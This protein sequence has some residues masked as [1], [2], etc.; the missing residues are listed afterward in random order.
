MLPGK[1]DDPVDRPAVFHKR[2]F[3]SIVDTAT[4]GNGLDAHSVR[5]NRGREWSLAKQRLVI[6]STFSDDE[7]IDPLE[8]G[9]KIDHVENGA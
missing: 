5:L 4:D 2:R 6:E 3:P 7:K 9:T 1:R 8:S